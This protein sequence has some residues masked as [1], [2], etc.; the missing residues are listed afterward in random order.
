M[1]TPLLLSPRSHAAA[2]TSSTG[3]L[4]NEGSLSE[5]AAGQEAP[6]DSGHSS[7]SL[8]GCEVFTKE[9]RGRTDLFRCRVCVCGEGVSV[10]RSLFWGPQGGVVTPLWS[11][12]SIGH[13]LG[14][15]F[16]IPHPPEGGNPAPHSPASFS[17]REALPPQ[18]RAAREQERQTRSLRP[19]TPGLAA[20]GKSVLAPRGARWP[21]ALPG[22]CCGAEIT[23][24]GRVGWREPPR[25]RVSR[26]Q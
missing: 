19:R 18:E 5:E 24:T 25:S 23:G 3:P 16:L 22:C 2:H 21:L 6:S 15:T 9:G 26:K 10:T 17:E 20:A 11:C 13:N 7:S 12:N 14:T 8:Q 1:L 4:W